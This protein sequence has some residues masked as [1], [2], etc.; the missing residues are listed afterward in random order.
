[1]L[2]AL[3][4]LHC[5]SGFRIS[6]HDLNFEEIMAFPK[7]NQSF[8]TYLKSS[9]KKESYMCEKCCLDA[10]KSV[11]NSHKTVIIKC[12]HNLIEAISPL[13]HFGILTG[14]MRMAEARVE[15]ESTESMLSALIK[16]GK[17]D[18]ES[19]E[20]CSA[21]P[22]IKSELISS[23]I[24]VLTLCASQ[25]TLLN[26]D[27]RSKQT[28]GQL[29]MRYIHENFTDKISISDLCNAIGYSKSTVLSAFKKEYSTTVNSYITT[30]RLE[31]SKKMLTSENA[32]I[33]QIALACGFSDQSYF[34]KVF[35]ASYG[36]TPT[37]Y[38]R[39]K[40]N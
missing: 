28:V 16:N 22:A 27:G 29:A 25:L 23:F 17:T 30:L 39:E 19:R 32:S 31:R 7:K 4:E 20:I 8:C 36:I 15:G 37:D 35:S 26:D 13:Y 33:S 1:M 9:D 38:R 14:F 2:N 40:E 11:K 24:N 5:I 21:V 10:F 6:V 18:F 12:R 3:R 34:S